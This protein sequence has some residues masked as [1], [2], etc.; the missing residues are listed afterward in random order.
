MRVRVKPS[1]SL[2][3]LA[4]A[5]FLVVSVAAA[6]AQ[7]PDPLVGTWKLDV[8][9][10]SYKPGPGPKSATV[11][12]EPEGKAKGIK[13]SIDGVN[14]D[15]SPMKWGFTTQRDGKEVPVTGN[16]AYDAATTTMA[17]PTSGTTVYTKGGKTVMT[18][19]AAVSAD[20]KTLTLT[21]TGTDA[22]GQAVHNVSVYTK[23]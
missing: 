5:S 1:V 2:G 20:G 13:V 16:P 9:K 17:S 10:S 12:V 15:G 11:V 7:A 3:L 21:G 8:A 18:S 23:Q 22:K 6:L 19:K 14:S 4:V